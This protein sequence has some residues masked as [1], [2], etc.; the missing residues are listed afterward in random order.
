MTFG[1]IPFTHLE[2]VLREYG[3][4][5]VANY[6]REL[7]APKVVGKTHVR[8]VT[9]NTGRLARSLK[10]VVERRGSSFVL[11][12]DFG[13]EYW[14]YLEYGTGP[15]RG[16]KQYWPNMGS[17]LN[18][19]KTKPVPPFKGKNGK[20]YTDT[21]RAFLIARRIHEVGTPP[22]HLLQNSLSKEEEIIQRCQD[23][24]AEDV[25]EWIEN[26]LNY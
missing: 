17:I 23:A 14:E 21:Q 19:V 9:Q 10:P 7:L 22:L 13:V 5:V 6:R 4:E 11:S 25:S 2:A 12:I 8:T 15:S 1:E 24:A 20:P 3:L 16:R 18:W 26:E